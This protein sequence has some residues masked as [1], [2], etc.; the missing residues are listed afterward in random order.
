MKTIE[1]L[2]IFL[3]PKQDLIDKEL[4]LKETR[5]K[6]PVEDLCNRHADIV[7][8]NMTMVCNIA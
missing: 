4:N 7:D 2:Y 5:G 3:F 6:T 1:A 8:L